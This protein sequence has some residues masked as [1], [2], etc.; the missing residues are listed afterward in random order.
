M[1]ASIVR[2]SSWPV[3][4]NGELHRWWAAHDDIGSA[5]STMK[6]KFTGSIRGTRS[7]NNPRGTGAAKHLDSQS[8]TASITL[9]RN[10]WD[11]RQI[12]DNAKLRKTETRIAELECSRTAQ[13]IIMDTV[14]AYI[15]MIYFQKEALLRE[16]HVRRLRRLLNDTNANIGAGTYTYS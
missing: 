8:S 7:R 16:N 5:N 1:F 2:N 13:Q 11:D 4:L 15:W 10:L 9:S 12:R 6:L 14:D 3:P